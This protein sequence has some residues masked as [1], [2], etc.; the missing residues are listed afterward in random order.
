MQGDGAHYLFIRGYLN[1]IRATGWITTQILWMLFWLHLFPTEKP[2]QICNF[3]Q[4]L[5]LIEICLSLDFPKG[6]LNSSM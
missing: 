5:T 4:A 6:D 1:F 2:L 3:Q